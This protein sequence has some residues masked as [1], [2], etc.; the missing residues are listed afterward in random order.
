M[1]LKDKIIQAAYDLFA[2]KGFMKTT[3]TDIIKSA[4]ASKG[5]FYHH[6][7]SKEDIVDHIMQ[8]Y[9]DDIL[10]YFDKIYDRYG[11]DYLAT[12]VGVFDTINAYKREQFDRWPEMV[13]I[14]SFPGNDTIIMKMGQ[15]FEQS[16]IQFYTDLIHRG[17]HRVWEVDQ[18]L[19]TATLWTKELLMIYQRTST[20]LMDWS[21]EHLKALEAQIAFDETLLEHLL[22]TDQLK[23]KT[24]VMQ[25]VHDAK[26]AMKDMDFTH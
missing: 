16:M 5:G 12:F 6:F 14:L 11:D 4:G 15:S 17:N 9:L 24:I 8:L 7:S 10:G 22:Q 19:Q 2:S 13:R 18:P 25:Y 3:I 26:D 23:I 20:L 21:D 1:D